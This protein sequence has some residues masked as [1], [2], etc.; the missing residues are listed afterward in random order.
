MRVTPVVLLLDQV[1]RRG[2]G[3]DDDG[4]GEERAAV[5]AGKAEAD[6]ARIA[7]VGKL[8]PGWILIAVVDDDDAQIAMRLPEK[9]FDGP[10]DIALPGVIGNASGDGGFGARHSILPRSR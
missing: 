5:I 7:H 1:P 6:E 3:A 2:D 10:P 8:I 9:A 4:V